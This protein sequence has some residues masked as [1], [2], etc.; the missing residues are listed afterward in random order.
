MSLIA[1]NLFIFFQFLFSVK[2]KFTSYFLRNRI[3]VPYYKMLFFFKNSNFCFW[4][5]RFFQIDGKFLREFSDYRKFVRITEN[6][7]RRVSESKSQFFQSH[8]IF[9]IFGNVQSYSVSFLNLENVRSYSVL[10]HIWKLPEY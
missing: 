3:N 2:I 7:K 8:F 4:R 10:F 9:A 1:S 6:K 5:L